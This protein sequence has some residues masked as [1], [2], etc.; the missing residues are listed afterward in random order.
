[1]YESG[2]V[3]VGVGCDDDGDGDVDGSSDS[4]TCKTS[5]IPASSPTSLS[6]FDREFSEGLGAMVIQ[7][8]HLILVLVSVRWKVK[9]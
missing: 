3:G 4:S 6:D 1:M 5:G 7:M 8:R 2:D 9:R